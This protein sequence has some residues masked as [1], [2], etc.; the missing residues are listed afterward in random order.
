MISI[1]TIF[2]LVT[3]KL[4]EY[5]SVFLQLQH[6]YADSYFILKQNKK[7]LKAFWLFICEYG[8]YSL[9]WWSLVRRWTSGLDFLKNN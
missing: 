1:R 7:M 6:S 8:V 2:A 3:V 4:D 9:L 5:N